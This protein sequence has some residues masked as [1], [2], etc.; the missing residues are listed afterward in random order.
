M[1]RLQH[2]HRRDATKD[3]KCYQQSITPLQ[4]EGAHMKASL[5]AASRKEAKSFCGGQEAI[6]GLVAAKTGGHGLYQFAMVEDPWAVSWL[7]W[8]CMDLP[9]SAALVSDSSV[10]FRDNCQILLRGLGISGFTLA[11]LRTGGATQQ[12]MV[13]R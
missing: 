7:Q 9:S 5:S 2:M 1:L 12:L 3:G 4:T 13:G 11:S 10:K 8:L 6:L